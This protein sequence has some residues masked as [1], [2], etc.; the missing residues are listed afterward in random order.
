MDSVV[1]KSVRFIAARNKFRALGQREIGS[2]MMTGLIDPFLLHSMS[3]CIMWLYSFIEYKGFNYDK[4][5]LIFS[6]KNL[7]NFLISLRKVLLM[8]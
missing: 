1:T 5:W 7:M 3:D 2:A 4:S 6:D 8:M